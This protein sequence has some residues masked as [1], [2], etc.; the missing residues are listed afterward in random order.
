MITLMSSRSRT[1][2]TA[3]ASSRSPTSPT[4]RTVPRSPLRAMAVAA[5]RGWM[6][7]YTHGMAIEWAEAR[8][9]EIESDLWELLHDPDQDVDARHA[10][11]A[12]AMHVLARLV[13][14][15]PDDLRWRV[16]RSDV[17][18]SLALRRAIAMS[19]AAAIVFLIF[20][21]L[22]AF[23][24]GVPSGRPQVVECATTVSVARTRAEY[25]EQV[26][27]CAGAFFTPRGQRNTA[28]Q[29]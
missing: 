18:D 12:P 4:V 10:S 13:L 17:E 5:V 2:E 19:A 16:E 25:R 3:P 29:P 6:R 28:T 8:R 11:L 27:T 23:V 26:M 24:W 22:P 15:I 9:A 20:W 1:S 21:V 7:V 14:G